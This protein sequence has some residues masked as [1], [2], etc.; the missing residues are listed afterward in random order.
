VVIA[1]VHSENGPEIAYWLGQ[2]P[3]EAARI[4][5]LSAAPLRVA[6]EIGKVGQIIAAAP[7][8]PQ[9]LPAAPAPTPAAEPLPPPITPL[10][11]TNA[12]A[13]ERSLAEVGTEGSMEEYAARRNPTLMN[14]RRASMFGN[15]TH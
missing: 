5:A 12:N 13:Y 7:L 6:F 8:E 1:M 4:A 15:R 10:T 3:E 9:P 11:G 14:E 2:H